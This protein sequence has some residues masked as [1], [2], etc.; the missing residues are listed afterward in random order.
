MAVEAS[1]PGKA[2]LLGEHSVVYRGPAVVLA[3]DRRAR[4]VAEER[5][6]DRIRI[7]ALDLGFSG[8]F[9]GDA[10]HPERGE[11]WRGQ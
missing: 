8:H 2:I 6:D 5:S 9:V 11:A 1:A 4:V 7:D 3:I 10:Y